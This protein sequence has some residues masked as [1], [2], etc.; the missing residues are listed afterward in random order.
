MT[1]STSN[2]QELS[3]FDDASIKTTRTFSHVLS[4]NWCS[5]QARLMFSFDVTESFCLD[6]MHIAFSSDKELTF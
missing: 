5:Y 3:L 1:K 6:P 4:I 2:V